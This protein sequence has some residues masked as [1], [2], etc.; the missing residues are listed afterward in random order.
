MW[1]LDYKESW[2]LRTDA[3][4]LWC[5]RRLLRVPWIARRSNQSILKGISLEYS[6]EGL[7]L[8]QNS[9]TLATWCK[10][11][12]YWKRPWCWEGLKVGEEG[13]DR[14][15]DGWIVSLTRWTRLWANSGRSWRTGKPSRLQSM[16]S[17]KVGHDWATEL[18]TTPTTVNTVPWLLF[19]YIHVFQKQIWDH[20]AKSFIACFSG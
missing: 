6:L 14:G 4:E 2:T 5:W 20:I 9:N 18:N 19:M 17:Q 3:Y 16:G 11:L 1:E 10:E 8:K 13:D 12:T 15:W 7:M